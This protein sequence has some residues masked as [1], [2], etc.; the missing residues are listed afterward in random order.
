MYL[1]VPV[2][3]AQ[4]IKFVTE[5][6]KFYL[7]LVT[8]FMVSEPKQNS[9]IICPDFVPK[10]QVIH[11]LWIDCWT[12]YKEIFMVKSIDISLNLI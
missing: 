4:K 3:E 11:K 7:S 5:K 8:N 6:L 12:A 10:L 2:L 9:L 1:E